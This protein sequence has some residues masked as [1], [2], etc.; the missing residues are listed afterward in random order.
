MPLMPKTP[1]G[2]VLVN[3]DGD[4]VANARAVGDALV[5]SDLDLF[6]VDGR[7]VLVDN[8]AL[9]PVAG[10]VLSEVVSKHL[11]TK[12]LVNREGKWAVAYKP[13]ACDDRMLRILLNGKDPR[14]GDD[15][16]GGTLDSR[17]P[18]A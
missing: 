5:E 14:T 2:R 13:V 9:V 12:Q 15:V 16:R 18:R 11:A 6:N 7:P 10:K 3:L 17:L 4:A 8:G 1:D